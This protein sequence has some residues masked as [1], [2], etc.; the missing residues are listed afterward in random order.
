MWGLVTLPVPSRFLIM[1]KNFTHTLQEFKERKTVLQSPPPVVYLESVRGCV[2]TCA[3]CH[4]SGSK[5]VRAGK[6]LL[7]KMEPYY[8]D[9]EVLAIHGLGEP[10]L[11]DLDYFVARAVEHDLV[12]HMNTTAFFLNK[13]IADKLA[14]TRLSIRFSIHSGRPETYR[15]VMGQDFTKIKNNIAYL[16]QRT[17]VTGKRPYFCFSCIVMKEN[18][19]EIEDFLRLAAELRIPEVRFQRLNPN[20]HSLKGQKFPDRDFTFRYYEQFN[21][22]VMRTFLERK[23]RY[24]ALADELGLNIGWGSMPTRI[25]E[26]YNWKNTVNSASNFLAGRN[27]FPLQPRKGACLAP[28]FGQLLVR[29]SGKVSLCCG[30]PQ[31]VLGDLKDADLMDIWNGP[32]MQK[33]REGFQ[34]GRIPRVCGYCNGFLFNQYPSNAFPGLRD[35]GTAPGTDR[36]DEDTANAGTREQPQ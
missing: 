6:E 31:Y 27:L 29:Q 2:Y 33:V 11:A 14:E 7:D 5:P 30:A 15:R 20:F 34:N 36:G 21:R 12:L 16:V 35:Q 32:R 26:G 9:M 3:M 1:S 18:I 23:P 28:W 13:K 10:L 4:I 25:F 22:E 24:K 8:K 17:E 19:D